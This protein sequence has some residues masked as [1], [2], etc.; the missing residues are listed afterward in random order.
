MKARTILLVCVSGVIVAGGISCTP[1]SG[2]SHRHSATAGASSVDLERD[3]LIG[4][5][6]ARK[7][8]LRINFQTHTYPED[9]SGIQLMSVQGDAIFV[10]DGVNFLTRLRRSNGQ[11]L[12]RLPIASRL[13]IIQ[14]ITYQPLTERVFL[15]STS[16]LLVLDDDTGSMIDKQDLGQIASTAPVVYG[17]F[18]IYGSRNGQV[19]WH[20]S[21]VGYQWRG[22]QV[23]P[24][25][26]VAPL[27]VGGV[28]VVTGS[29]GR[30]M[31]LDA[32]SAAGIWNKR[33]L[34]EVA[35]APTTHDGL[36]Y[37]AGLDQYLWAI[38]L[39]SGRTL[40]K[41]LAEVP[42]KNPPTV[43]DGQLYVQIQGTGLHCF[44]PHPLD[45]PGGEILW[46]APD[47]TGDVIGA[48]GHR[49][50]VWDAAARVLAIVDAT[51]GGVMTT[52]ALPDVKHL[53]M[54]GTDELYAAGD[55][56]RV[57]SLSPTDR[58]RTQ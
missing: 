54:L 10:L 41:Y 11:R 4:Y 34:N 49:L 26:R 51:R 2:P 1:S 22:Y 17:E 29:D 8:G 13:D 42:L 36:L 57:I 7:L 38:D 27:L 31:V 21:Q 9:E 52:V 37:I 19:V 3:Y 58:K 6:S 46:T 32:G 14:G 5:L 53:Y 30:V 45:T 48:H 35:A 55:D 33:L 50:F 25:I 24:T 20:S 15:T 44:A 18:F 23:S 12:W 40:W 16:H 56:G 28:I 43:L 39:A 47:V